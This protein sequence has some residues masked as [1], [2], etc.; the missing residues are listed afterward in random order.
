MFC[1]SG[2]PPT[3][4]QNDVTTLRKTAG[5]CPHLQP[6]HR[7]VQSIGLR[8]RSLTLNRSHLLGD[9]KLKQVQLCFIGPLTR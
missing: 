3:K 9:A 2:Q 6:S 8:S 1:A 7:M 4:G 5:V